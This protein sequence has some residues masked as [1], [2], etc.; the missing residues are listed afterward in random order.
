MPYE[1]LLSGDFEFANIDKIEKRAW[2]RYYDRIGVS[3]FIVDKPMAIVEYDG[4][5]YEFV[6]I[7]ASCK[8]LFIKSGAL[9]IQTIYDN[10]N[11]P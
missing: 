6:Y 10:M 7:N 4:K 5:V 1:E 3:N 9:D 8:E 2:K 11:K